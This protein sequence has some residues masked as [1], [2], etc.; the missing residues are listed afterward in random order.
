[1]IKD[2]A[3]RASSFP[4]NAAGEQQM[5]RKAGEEERVVLSGLEHHHP[6][7]RKDPCLGLKSGIR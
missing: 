7:L 2:S 1:M 4:Q 6:F 5:L 3:F